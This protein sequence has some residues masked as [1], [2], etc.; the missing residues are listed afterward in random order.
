MNF[1]V[2]ELFMRNSLSCWNSGD[3]R[4]YFLFSVPSNSFVAIWSFTLLGSVSGVAAEFSDDSFSHPL[5]VASMLTNL[6]NIE[7]KWQCWNSMLSSNNNVE[8]QYCLSKRRC[9][10]ALSSCE[11][12][13]RAESR[14]PNKS[15]TKRPN[16]TIRPNIEVLNLFPD[17]SKYN[18]YPI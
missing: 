2:S 15:K 11:L 8:I 10:G 1:L 5:F 6:C 14:R 4:A 12:V 9:V 17:V 18:S 13:D 7:Q 3:F 16:L